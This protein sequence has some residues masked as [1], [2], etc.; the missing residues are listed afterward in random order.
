MHLDH[1]AKAKQKCTSVNVCTTMTLFRL[2][3]VCVFHARSPAHVPLKA[4]IPKCKVFG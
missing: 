1:T 3:F 4:P 2:S